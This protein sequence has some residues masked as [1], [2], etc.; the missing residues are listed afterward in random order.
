M[1]KAFVVATHEFMTNIKKP[2]FLWAAFGGPIFSVVLVAVVILITA[3]TAGQGDLEAET[4]AYVDQTATSILAEPINKPEQFVAYESIDAARAALDAEEIDAYFVLPPLYL[5]AGR[6]QVYSYGNPSDALQDEIEVFLGANVARQIDADVSADLLQDPVD[7]RIYLENSGRELTEGG[8][9]GVFMVPFIFAFIFL[10]GIQI[11]STFLMSS[12][13]EEKTSRIIEILITTISPN[14]LLLGKLLGLGVLGLL[15]LIIWMGVGGVGFLLLGD[16]E[17]LSSV[18][19][20]LDMVLLAI[21]YFVLSY[22]LISSLLAGVGAITDSEQE[23]R[24]YAGL[25]SFI[26]VIP[27]VAL[28]T[29]ITDPNGPVPTLLSL[30]PFTSGISMI[31]R[32]GFTSVPA[33]QIVISIVL[34]IITTLI[35][36]WASAKVFR[37]ALLLYGKKPSLRSIIRTIFGR[38]EAGVMVQTAQ[39]TPQVSKES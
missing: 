14:Q 11:T 25:V 27:L 17:F 8:I 6:V 7:M 23:S 30:I 26:Y 10:F 16:T 2:S 13:V 21:V 3:N 28:V 33:D 19:I 24:A 35:I 1:N 9:L 39:S 36:V 32:L 22:F 18:S 31:M 20:P 29:F 5:Q 4:I 12:V 34:I 37:W 15:Q 38:A